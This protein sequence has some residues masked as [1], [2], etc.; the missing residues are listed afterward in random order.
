MLLTIVKLIHTVVT[1]LILQHNDL[2]ILQNALKA[3]NTSFV[4]S[5]CNISREPALSVSDVTIGRQDIK[6]RV[7]GHS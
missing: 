4:S 3:R 6:W 7:Q 2:Q 1:P 5:K